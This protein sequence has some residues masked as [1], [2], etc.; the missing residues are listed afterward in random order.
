[1]TNAARGGV[2]CRSRKGTRGEKGDV[3]TRSRVRCRGARRCRRRLATQGIEAVGGTPE[4]LQA[5]LA[6]ELVKWGR[7]IREANV[8]IE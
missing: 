6:E 4:S 3:E 1:M 5:E 2:G 8:K 7:V